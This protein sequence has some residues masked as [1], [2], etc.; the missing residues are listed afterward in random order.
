MLLKTIWN[1]LAVY[2]LQ[3]LILVVVI[4]LLILSFRSAKTKKDSAGGIGGKV[5][6]GFREFFV[7]LFRLILQSPLLILF[8]V[9]LVFLRSPK[10]SEF[11]IRFLKGLGIPVKSGSEK[12]E[13]EA[14]GH[15]SDKEEIKKII[16]EGKRLLI[17][18][19]APVKEVSLKD[20][21][22]ELHGKI[23][24]DYKKV[25]GTYVYHGI[26]IPDLGENFTLPMWVR[27]QDILAVVRGEKNNKIVV[28]VRPQ[29]RPTQAK[30]EWDALVANKKSG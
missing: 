1:A 12:T 22:E 16:K 17:P 11:F 9:I 4:A 28:L 21:K 24:Y 23:T 7:S 8:V 30:K 10:L 14:H 29:V 2:W 5:L 15:A 18:P 19:V 27:Y 25:P 20:L 3:T 13:F 26:F 6:Y